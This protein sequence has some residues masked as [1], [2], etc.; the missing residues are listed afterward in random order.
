VAEQ[1]PYGHGVGRHDVTPR[2]KSAGQFQ[3]ACGQKNAFL[4]SEKDSRRGVL[5]ACA[6]LSSR[7]AERLLLEVVPKS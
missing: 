5:Q 1:F 4:G 2:L 6:Q 3:L 7:Y